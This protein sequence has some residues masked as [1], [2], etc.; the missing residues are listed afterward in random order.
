MSAPTPDIAPGVAPQ[1][2]PVEDALPAL[3]AALDRRR[4]AVLVAPPGAGKTTL[5]PLAL[6]AEP[7]AAGGKLILLEPRRVAARAAAERLASLLGEDLGASIGLRMRGETVPGRR[8]EVVTDGVLSRLLM[9]APDLPGIVGLIFDEVHERALQ[10]DF[11][12]ALALEI[13]GALRNDLRILAMS[14]T[15]DADALA[16]RLDARIVSSEGRMHPVE[17]RWLDKPWRGPR[18]RARL[19]DA[20]ASHAAALATAEHGSLLVFL[21]GVGEIRRTAASLSGRLPDDMDLRELHGGLP[22][23]AQRAA[24]APA[25]PGRRKCVLSTSIAETS[26]TIEGVRLVLDAGQARRARLDPASGMSRLVTEPVSRAEADQRR[27]RAGRLEPGVCLRLWTRG[28]EGALPAHPPP[29]IASADLAPLALDLAAWGADALP[30]L[31]PPPEAALNEARALLRGLEALD[32]DDVITSHGRRMAALPAHPRLAHMMLRTAE[33]GED[34][35]LACD[36]AAL[37]EERDPLPPG[38]PADFALRLEALRSP[39]TYERDRGKLDRARLAPARDAAKRLA[40]ALGRALGRAAPKPGAGR[41]DSAAA[42]RLIARAYPDRVA[43]RRPER[44]AGEA[45]RYLLSG[46]KGAA[47]AAA[48]ALGAQRFLAVADTDGDPREARIRRA[49]PLS[50]SDV[51][52][53]FPASIRDEDVC[54][55]SPRHRAV[56]A[57]RRRRLG[58]LALEDAPWRDAPTDA[59]AGALAEGVLDLGLDALPWSDAAMRLRARVAFAREADEPG[60]PDWSDVALLGRLDAWLTPHLGG[61][62]SADDLKRLDLAA[63]LDA[64]LDWPSR[65]SLDR[66]APPRWTTPAGTRAPIDYSGE[67]PSIALRVQELFGLDVHPTIAGRP[68]RLELL[69]PARR[70][71]AVT[72]DLPGFWRAGYQDLRKDL[73]G[74][75]PRHPWPEEPWRAEPTTRTK[76]RGA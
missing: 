47:L 28:E 48:D 66:A 4:N 37:L 30:F 17:S 3:R 64:S 21:P 39:E 29:E 45:P 24:L 65:Q 2:L 76:P 23:K 71:A 12:L 62:R 34:A 46:G 55:W 70:P 5:A 11:A 72:S 1:G 15:V 31:D 42:A 61:L 57:R 53:L 13:Q 6:A 63:V 75:Y 43:L 51:E 74:R 68:L 35:A 22:L 16:R 73:R 52:T 19:E 26:L 67:G 8:I 10:S 41:V 38:A 32:A 59:I 44:R 40:G 18:S 54:E 7:W 56:V 25:A 49:L 36:V 14:A 50:A 60:L 9:D 20:V 58:A 33:A 27:G 69:S